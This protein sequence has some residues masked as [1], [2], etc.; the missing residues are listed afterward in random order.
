M[1][2]LLAL[3]LCRLLKRHTPP[4]RVSEPREIGLNRWFV[5]MSGTCRRCGTWRR[6]RREVPAPPCDHVFPHVCAECR[7]RAEEVWAAAPSVASV[8]DVRPA[9]EASQDDLIDLESGHRR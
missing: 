2:R 3:I 5:E 8:R 9:T 7:D 1:T 4:E 6:V